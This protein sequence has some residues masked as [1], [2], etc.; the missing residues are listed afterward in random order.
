[1]HKYFVL[2][3][4]LLAGNALAAPVAEAIP[5]QH[6]HH[7]DVVTKT[8]KHYHTAFAADPAEGPAPSS[9]PRKHRAALPGGSE[10][11]SS[12]STPSGSD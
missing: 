6:H 2:A 3:I 4:A 8:V 10:S 1:M 11:D 9:G 12:D 5:E 7:G